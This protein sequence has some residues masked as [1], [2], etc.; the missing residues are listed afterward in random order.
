MEGKK[1]E[2]KE[3]EREEMKIMIE[4]GEGKAEGRKK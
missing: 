3:M 2:R 1:M 4:S